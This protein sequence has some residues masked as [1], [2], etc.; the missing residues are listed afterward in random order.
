MK[1]ERGFC[2]W[3]RIPDTFSFKNPQLS[4]L[5]NIINKIKQINS[6]LIVDTHLKFQHSII[7]KIFNS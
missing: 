1:F 5:N 3:C 4:A 7:A 2:I 6:R